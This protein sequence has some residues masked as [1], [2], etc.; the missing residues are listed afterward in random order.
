[1]IKT[2]A[3]WTH[4]LAGGPILVFGGPYSNLA[5]T[6]AMRREAERL[7]IPPSRVI[8]T[9][10]VVAYAAEPVETTAL[11][12]DWGCHVIAGNCE[13]QLGAGAG[14]CGCGFDEGTACDRMAKGWYAF[15]DRRMPEDD[16]AWM[17]ALPSLARFTLG[18]LSWAVVHGGVRQTNRFVFASDT[19][20]IR[21]ELSAAGTDVVIA[22]HAGLPFAARSGSLLWFNPG[23][24]GMPANDGTPEVWYGLITPQDLHVAFSLK[25]LGYD[26]LASAAAMRRSAHADGYA[27]T[28]V[29]GVWPTLDILPA[30]E[31]AATGKR[32]RQRTVSLPAGDRVR[33]R[34]AAA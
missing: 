22:G 26:H 13:E 20:A 9:G 21:E 31:R 12:R 24:I 17:R 30:A 3:N 16:R 10:D 11:I 8:C 19:Q 4:A 25:R 14:D 27:R 29:T 1:M 18:G 32:L 33:E 23:V 2:I 34:G 5:A 7:S 15:A 28:L 6:L